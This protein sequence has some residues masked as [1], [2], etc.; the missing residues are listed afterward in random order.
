MLALFCFFVSFFV[1]RRL[2]QALGRMLCR[3]AVLG[4]G[5][6]GCRGEAGMEDSTG[7]VRL[8]GVYVME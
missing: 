4:R 1:V 8:I 2:S 6:M 5:D 3:R 7:R